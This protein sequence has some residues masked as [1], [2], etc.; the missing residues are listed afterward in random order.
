MN[1]SIALFPLHQLYHNVL[2]WTRASTLER[3]N[4][5]S[6]LQYFCCLRRYSPFHFSYL[7]SFY[8]VINLQYFSFVLF[9]S[10][11][12]HFM[13]LRRFPRVETFFSSLDFMGL[14][15][16]S[17]LCS[18]F[19]DLFEICSHFDILYMVYITL[20]WVCISYFCLVISW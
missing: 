17:V 6:P 14:V 20:K 10:T 8:Y 1:I 4:I 19:H 2:D 7:Y 9:L 16:T 5:P 12:F 18:H 15:C 11:S 3:T 13:I